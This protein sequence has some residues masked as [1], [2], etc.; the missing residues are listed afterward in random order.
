MK[1]FFAFATLSC[2]C[3]VTFCA[4]TPPPAGPSDQSVYQALVSANCMTA[5]DAGLGDIAAEHALLSSD[6]GQNAP[7]IQAIGC[8]FDGGTI[9][10][11]HVTCSQG[12][13]P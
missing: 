11:C 1:F 5:T 6:A 2:A 4:Q 9:A 12:A 7:L 8:L 3:Q 10:S 13:S